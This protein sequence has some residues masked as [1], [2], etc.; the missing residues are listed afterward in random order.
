MCCVWSRQEAECFCLASAV[1][2]HC[3]P[4]RWTEEGSTGH[5]GWGPLPGHERGS[6]ACRVFYGPEEIP[7]AKAGPGGTRL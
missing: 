1:I 2:G 6:K 7:A 3:Q 4:R 5:A